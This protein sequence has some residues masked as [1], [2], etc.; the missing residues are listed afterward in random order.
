MIRKRV[1]DAL[2]I[3]AGL[4]GLQ[5]ASVSVAQDN[6]G[7]STETAGSSP[8]GTEYAGSLQGTPYTYLI[9]PSGHVLNGTI[10]G[11]E[12]APGLAIDDPDRW[13]IVANRDRMTDQVQWSIRHYQTGLM[14]SVNSAGRITSVCVIGSNF[15]G[16]SGMLRVGNN[17]AIAVPNDCNSRVGA[18]LQ[19][20]LLQGGPLLVRRYEWPYDYGQDKEGIADNFDKAVELFRWLAA[21]PGG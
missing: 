2:I 18:T 6:F 13:V 7:S 20:Q 8:V 21:R 4:A 17:S 3:T 19:A 12:N 1:R 14:L 5:T 9:S 15:P 16:R 10:D 11:P